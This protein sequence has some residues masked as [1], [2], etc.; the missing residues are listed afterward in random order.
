MARKS[1]PKQEQFRCNKTS[2]TQINH[3]PGVKLNYKYEN[4]F[5]D[6]GKGVCC[7]VRCYLIST[8][9][10]ISDEHGSVNEA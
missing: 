4:P 7:M 10:A 1:F 8:P 9:A 2:G 3:L 6:S 5:A